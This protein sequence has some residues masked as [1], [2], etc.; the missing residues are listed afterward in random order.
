M[1]ENVLVTYA[2]KMGATASIAAGVGAELR[3]AGHTVDVHEIS[4]VKA[5]SEYDVVIL[6]SAIYEGRWR[7]EAV[8]FLQF[9][10]KALRGRKVWLFHSGP[11][12]PSSDQPEEV[13]PDVARLAAE[14]GV[15]TVKTF[16]GE[17][18]E[19]IIETRA[20]RRA[21]MEDLV[22]DARDW[23]AVRA[24]ADEIESAL[25]AARTSR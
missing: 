21:G 12:G 3:R 11:V 19:D 17:L 4:D 23:D 1:S 2:T 25:G 9:H 14:I 7:P 10:A 5:A 22:G 24:W 8:E 6:G 18:Q 20:A 16:P 13:P 15:R